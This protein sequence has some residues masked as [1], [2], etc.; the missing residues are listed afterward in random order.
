MLVLIIDDHSS[1]VIQAIKLVLCN[2]T[3]LPRSA[4]ARGATRPHAGTLPSFSERQ[5]AVLKALLQGK[6]NKRIARDLNIAEGTVKAHLWAVYQSLGVRT[7]AQ[8]MYRAHEL[9]LFE[10]TRQ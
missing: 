3:Y 5:F 4:F 6:Q 1:A 2:G 7:R 10:L 9:G 8:A